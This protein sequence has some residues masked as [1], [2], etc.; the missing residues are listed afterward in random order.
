MGITNKK[1]VI[2]GAGAAGI[3]SAIYLAKQGYKVNIIEKNS[4][5]GGRCGQIIKDG[6]RFDIGPTMLM[7]PDVLENT[8]KDFGKN[9]H[10]E[11]DLLRLDP[12]YVIKMLGQEEFLFSTD[13]NLMEKQFEAIESGS[14]KKYEQLMKESYTRYKLSMK[15]VVNRNYYNFF[16]FFNPAN[17]LLFYKLKAFRDHYKYTGKYFKDEFLRTAF[18][19]QNLYLGQD[20]YK[21]PALFTILPAMEL[22]DGV[23]FPK[24]GMYKII[25]KLVAIAQE[26]GVE[27]TYNTTVTQI[28][29]NNKKV[30]GVKTN[31]DS[32]I[33]AD[34]V[35]SNVDVP[36]A[37]NKLLPKERN[38]KF[39][40]LNYTC[41]AFVF[42]WGVSKTYNQLDQHN[43]FIS[44]EFKKGINHIF[45]PK[46]GEKVEPSMFYIHAP[47]RKDIT[48]APNSQDSYTIIVQTSNLD[49]INNDENQRKKEA[50]N[51]VIKRL[52]AEGLHDIEDNI[53]FE[54]C[55]T[56]RSWQSKFNLTLGGTFGSVAHNILQMGYFRPN[57]QHKRYKNL[58]FTGGSTH[59]G[60]GLPLAIT[61]GRLVS[62][63]ILKYFN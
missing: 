20:P 2:I 52:K 11:I 47:G 56:P 22:E 6:H 44:P 40:K 43:V 4:I 36:Y 10:T 8:F 14:F 34:I 50:R 25:E 21:S 55:F 19:L 38:D 54:I 23:W 1:A 29:T 30:N 35:I 62:E 17:M 45:Y 32:F 26:E 61:S 33:E 42:H 53:K 13:M 39:N 12:G 41:S 49:V 37:Y 51:A 3:T 48:A 7:M 28:E 16:E 57:S 9:L 15:E 18:T 59:P 63:K 46:D 27:F 5:P 60:N 58:F 24:G 31:V